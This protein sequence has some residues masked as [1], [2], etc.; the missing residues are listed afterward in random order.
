MSLPYPKSVETSIA[1]TDW[2]SITDSLR[3]IWPSI[4]DA[5][6]AYLAYFP[7]R[8]AVA[9]RLRVY[10]RPDSGALF[11]AICPSPPRA[12]DGAAG[13]ILI[14]HLESNYFK[15]ARSDDEFERGHESLMLQARSAI[16][17]ACSP[18]LSP[19]PITVVDYADLETEQFWAEVS[20]SE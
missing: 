19:L 9:D 3:E 1:A 14:P 12:H 17:Q 5:A 10:I 7:R 15:L 8:T 11:Y 6:R 2:T 18:E 13:F 20:S 4:C 16:K